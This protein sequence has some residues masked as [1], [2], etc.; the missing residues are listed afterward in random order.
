MENRTAI[1]RNLNI[2]LLVISSVILAVR[3]YVRLWMI[4]S[5]GLD[6]VFAVLAWG[7]LTTLSALEIVET[8]YGA[9]RQ[10]I[11]VEP[12]DLAKFFSILPTMQLL[13]LASTGLVR[14]SIATFL[15]RLNKE[16]SFKRLVWVLEAAISIFTIICF[17]ILLFE[18]RP[19]RD[20][21]NKSA[22]G[23][24]CL[25]SAHENRLWYTHASFGILFDCILLGLPMWILY[26]KMMLNAT[27]IK[28][29][30]IFAVGI[31]SA[32]TGIIRLSMIL[33]ID[34]TKNTTFNITFASVWTDLE[35]HTGLWVAC[36]PTLRPF[37]RLVSHK[38]GLRSKLRSTSPH[39]PSNTDGYG[40]DSCGRYPYGKGTKPRSKSTDTD[41]TR[42]NCSEERIIGTETVVELK[43]LGDDGSSG[44]PVSFTKDEM[45]VV[46]TAEVTQQM[47]GK[48]DWRTENDEQLQNRGAWL[49][50]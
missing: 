31:F 14:L 38:L 24:K 29:M 3:L 49:A 10:M 6:D 7:T 11:S 27:T 15:P 26:S 12:Q 32:I 34:M 43:Y 20:L 22:P 19:V 36:F 50:V 23:A 25:S 16:A 8:V 9:G 21:W 45:G 46:R 13:Y 18:C 41:P 4:R 44:S 35:G 17:S 47:E 2:A 30:L 42:G 39:G 40:K 48:G 28:V 33:R 5:P 37:L 1:V